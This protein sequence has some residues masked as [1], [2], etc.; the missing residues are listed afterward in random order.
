[1]VLT[2]MPL[3]DF[4]EWQKWQPAW[5]ELLKNSTAF[6]ARVFLSFEWLAT[7]W[8]H[9]GRGRLLIITVSDGT[10]LLA[11]AP[12]FISFT[13]AIR[14]IGSGNADYGDFLARRGYEEAAVMIWHWLFEHRSLWNV[15]ALHELPE[16]SI[17]VGAMHASPLPTWLM[18]RS[19]QGEPCHRIVFE[20]RST[21]T[22]HPKRR[23]RL[24]SAR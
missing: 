15:I 10:H 20:S 22:P 18:A 13:H 3:T 19:L 24:A 6:E 11:A 8:R 9:L 7:W 14:F 21:R 2:V 4:W 12:L 5:D 17:A 1:M 23:N 16:S